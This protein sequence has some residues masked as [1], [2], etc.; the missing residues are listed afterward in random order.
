MDMLVEHAARHQNRR[1]VPR[2]RPQ[3]YAPSLNFVARL[4]GPLDQ[5]LPVVRRQNPLPRL[6]PEQRFGAGQRPG[7]DAEQQSQC[8]RQRPQAGDQDL[9]SDPAEPLTEPDEERAR[10]FGRIRFGRGGHSLSCSL[11]MGGFPLPE[12]TLG[13]CGWQLSDQFLLG[14]SERQR[15]GA[16]RVG[17]N[18]CLD[19]PLGMDE[20][21]QEHLHELRVEQS[22]A[23]GRHSGCLQ[24]HSGP[25]T[26]PAQDDSHQQIAAC[27]AVSGRAAVH[28]D[29]L[30]IEA[31]VRTPFDQRPS[32]RAPAC[33]N[34]V[35][36]PAE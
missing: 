11:L 20:P 7:R 35:G 23:I 27:P 16:G 34:S 15:L 26:G 2:V 10:L 9:D 4:P 28:A 19:R 1:V 36:R 12:K 14:G 5:H 31:V 17:P 24:L 13:R 21:L 25:Q 33:P 18:L 22:P 8:R 32:K 3:K 30:R 6:R 29:T